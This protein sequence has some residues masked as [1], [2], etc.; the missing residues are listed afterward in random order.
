MTKKYV[1]TAAGCGAE[2]TDPRA[3]NYHDFIQHPR[4]GLCIKAVGDEVV[5][6][7]ARE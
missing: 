6:M 7:E 5:G 1:C 3:A 2:F 4:L